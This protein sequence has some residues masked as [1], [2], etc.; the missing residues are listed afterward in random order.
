MKE[1][2]ISV[3]RRKPARSREER[4]VESSDAYQPAGTATESSQ[5]NTEERIAVLAY[6]KAE[7]R[8]FVGDHELEDWLEA[9]RELK[10][11]ESAGMRN[12]EER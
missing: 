2:N 6:Y 3:T 11:G 10:G 4:W 8:G 7:R 12:E 9:E 1:S 5:P